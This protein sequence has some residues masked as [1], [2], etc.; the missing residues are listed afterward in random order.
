M[1]STLTPQSV[2]Q[3]DVVVN[4]LGP[5]GLLACI[6]LGRKGYT[7]HAVERWHEPYGRPRAVTFDHEIARILATIGIE[8]DDDA[9][10]DYHE[11]HYYWLNKHDEILLEPDWISKETN[12]YRNRYWF[13]Q[14]ELEER[15]RAIV[16]TLPSVTLH[17]GR[18]AVEFTQDEDGVTLTYREIK[19]GIFTVEFE[20][21]GEVGQIRARYA[22]GSDGAN[23]FIRRSTGLELTDLGFDANW[24]IVDL[25]PN[26]LPEYRTAHFQICDP[27]RPTTVVPGGP[28][29]RRWEF[30]ILPHE[31][32]AEFGAEEN[33][34]RLVEPW[35]MTPEN[36]V[37]ERAAVTRFQGKYLENWRKDRAVLVGDAAHL[38]PPF[39]GEGMCAGLRDT[40]NLI[41]RLDLVLQGEADVHLLDEWSNERREQAKWYIDFSVELGKVI[42]VTDEAAAA[43]RDERLKAEYAVQSKIGPTPT[44]EA[45]LGEGT[46]AADDALAGKTAIQGRVAHRGATGRFDDAVGRG[47][48]LLSSVGAEDDLSPD[49]AARLHAIGGERLSIGPVGSGA[50]VID[51][52]G[53]YLRWFAEHGIDHLLTRPD[54]YVALT[55]AGHDEL[56]A[57][58]DRLL[59][60]FEPAGA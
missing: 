56:S 39:A 12:G 43:D 60:S 51:T 9:S 36:A 4:G 20:E 28:G 1:T 58:F 2:H 34:W 41:W 29:R 10:I 55:A 46:W 38:M 7:V 31:D 17:N 19:K 57:R 8:S 47:W 53:V 3:A 59:R 44:H 13:S 32:P 54:Y 26:E 6:L 15:L 30:M 25:K 5:V 50:D 11:D 22:I 14:P 21:G 52:E 33:V 23:S 24:L 16:S 40:F 48:Y 18:E 42:C 35:G 27:A 45:V 49:R 37:L